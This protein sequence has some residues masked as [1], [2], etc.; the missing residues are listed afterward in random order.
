MEENVIQ[1]S[2]GITI[3]ADVSVKSV[4]YVKS[5]V[6]GVFPYVIEKMEKI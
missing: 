6:F 5:T 2:G 3:N 1:M 4:M